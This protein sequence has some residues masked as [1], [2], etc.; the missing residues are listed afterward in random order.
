MKYVNVKQLDK[1]KLNLFFQKHWGSSLMVISSGVFN[2]EDL[3]GYA[4]ISEDQIIGLVTY[5]D[6]NEEREIISLDSIIE[7]KGIGSNLMELVES[8]ARQHNIPKI[9]LITSNDNI[10]ALKFYQ[11]RGYRMVQIFP[12]AIDKAREIK[13]QIPLIGFHG[14]PLKDEILLEKVLS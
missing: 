12:N 13:T 8:E 3:P 10:N 2:C 4:C 5:V 6:K 7:N 11:K 14:I 9:K 1:D